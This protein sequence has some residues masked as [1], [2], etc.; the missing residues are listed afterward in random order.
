MKWLANE[1]LEFVVGECQGSLG[2]RRREREERKRDRTLPSGRPCIPW[3]DGTQKMPGC[4]DA[5]YQA[6]QDSCDKGSSGGQVSEQRPVKE[7]PTPILFCALPNLKREES[8][9]GHIMT[10][11]LLRPAMQCDQQ[12]PVLFGPRQVKEGRALEMMGIW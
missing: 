2:Q 8:S 3:R 10:E 5:G 6:Q 9:F 12:I 1:G 11:G 4:S 7:T